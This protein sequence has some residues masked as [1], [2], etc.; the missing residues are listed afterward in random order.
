MSVGKGRGRGFAE[1]RET[2]L[3]RPGQSFASQF[4][5]L[6]NLIENLVVNDITSGAKIDDIVH[7]ILESIKNSTP[8][9]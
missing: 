9:K 5:D 4:S 7:L 1:V 2:T 6:I 3:R 8:L